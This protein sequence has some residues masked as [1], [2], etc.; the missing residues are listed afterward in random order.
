[1]YIRKRRGKEKV[2]TSQIER[3]F[4]QTQEDFFSFKYFQLDAKFEQNFLSSKYES[5]LK[6][7]E[8]SPNI[9]Q[10]YLLDSLCKNLQDNVN[11]EEK[12]L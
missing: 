9:L 7:V 1:M 2:A 3:Y 10:Y 6:Q 5:D 4:S 11:K 8:I 12:I